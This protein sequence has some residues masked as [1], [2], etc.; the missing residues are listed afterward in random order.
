MATFID[1]KI[2]NQVFETK[3]S[4]IDKQNT[5]LPVSMFE[6]E[7][8]RNVAQVSEKEQMKYRNEKYKEGKDKPW[9][10]NQYNLMTAINKV[11]SKQPGLFTPTVSLL[12]EQIEINDDE[13]AEIKGIEKTENLDIIDKSM[14]KLRFG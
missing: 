2:P 3:T 5:I 12:D 7:L 13:Q 10:K 6:H 4:F 8:Y 1:K 9:L 11:T 14:R